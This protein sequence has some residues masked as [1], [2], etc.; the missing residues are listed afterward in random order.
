MNPKGYVYQYDKKRQKNS[1]FAMNHTVRDSEFDFDTTRL[2][3]EHTL[4][5]AQKKDG[6][7]QLVLFENY[8][9][10]STEE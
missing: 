7:A 3:K 4:S 1:D 2:K 8:R 10:Y 6:M 9:E 5:M